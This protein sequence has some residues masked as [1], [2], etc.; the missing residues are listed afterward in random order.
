[1]V[2]CAPM[3]QEDARLIAAAPEL[4]AGLVDMFALMDEG[5]LVRNIAQDGD[6]MWAVKAMS[7][8][9]RLRAAQIATQKAVSP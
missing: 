3:R 5:V 8:V 1:M 6:P 7:I 4:L 2:D 9:A